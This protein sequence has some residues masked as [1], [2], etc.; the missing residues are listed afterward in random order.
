[1]RTISLRSAQLSTLEEAQEESGW[2]LVHSDV[3]R[4]P[5]NYPMI[6]AVCAGTGVQIGVAIFFIMVFAVLGFLIPTNKGQC[7]TAIILLYVFSGSFAGY[8]SAR[9]Y[10]LFGGKNWKRNTLG[11]AVAFPGCLV[12]LFIVLDIGLISV[13]AA[14]AVSFMTVM[15]IFLLWVGVSTPLIFVGSYFGFRKQIIQVPLKSTQIARHIPEMNELNV[16]LGI[17]LGGFLPFAS[18]CIELFF[19][20][21][22]LWLSQIYYVFGFLF[23]VLLILALTCAEVSIVMCYFQL[24]NEDYR[25]WWMR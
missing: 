9:L 8:H 12:F 20:M 22:S 7:L 2:K 1:M 16:L 25:W 14:T 18:V 4:P 13:G 19:I 6:L 21:S 5:Q 3:F 11:T 15:T 23:I 24:C 10:K 17:I